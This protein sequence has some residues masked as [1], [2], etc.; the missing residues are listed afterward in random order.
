MVVMVVI[1]LVLTIPMPEQHPDGALKVPCPTSDVY[2]SLDDPLFDEN[3]L[4]TSLFRACARAGDP[5]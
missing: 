2:I 4:E 3:D 1:G 5:K